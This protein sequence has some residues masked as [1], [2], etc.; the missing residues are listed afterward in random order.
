MTKFPHYRQTESKDCGPTCLKIIAKHYG[1]IIKIQDLRDYCETNRFGS[2]LLML[3]DASEKIGLRSIGA[4]MSAEQLLEIPGH[5][6]K[7]GRIYNF[8]EKVTDGFFNIFFFS[9]R[10]FTVTF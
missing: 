9:T 1:K 10:R 5:I 3:S 7:L 8:E 2:N 4:K 6:K